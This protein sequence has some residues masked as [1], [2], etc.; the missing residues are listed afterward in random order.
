MKKSNFQIKIHYS[1]KFFEILKMHS[2][3]FLKKRFLKTGRTVGSHR[4]E[5]PRLSKC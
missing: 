1:R 3:K 4:K 2:A 5:A